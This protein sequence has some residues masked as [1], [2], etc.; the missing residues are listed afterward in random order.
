M[1]LPPAYSALLGVPSGLDLAL[2]AGPTVTGLGAG[3]LDSWSSGD[4]DDDND[5]EE[6][7]PQTPSTASHSLDSGGVM[8]Q[9]APRPSGLATVA[10]LME[11]PRPLR[12]ASF[13][14]GD[15]GDEELAPRMPLAATN[16][17][18]S[19]AVW[20]TNDEVG[21]E[22]APQVMIGSWILWHARCCGFGHRREF[23]ACAMAKGQSRA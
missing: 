19:G 6:L 3:R 16:G 7:A 2:E 18:D 13:S 11:F 23:R 14:S 22:L 21:G 8:L 17:P 4:V 12:D 9:L 5:D 10:Q 20:V 1:P 15:D